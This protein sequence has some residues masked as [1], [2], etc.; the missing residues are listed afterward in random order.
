VK[1]TSLVASIVAMRR[2]A[3]TENAGGKGP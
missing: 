3:G 2:G 1:R